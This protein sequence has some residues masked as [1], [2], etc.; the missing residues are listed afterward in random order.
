[1]QSSKERGEH[2]RFVEGNPGGPGRPRRTL[3]LLGIDLTPTLIY[4]LP[5]LTFRRG[6][7][8]AP[9]DRRTQGLRLGL[10]FRRPTFV[11]Y[12]HERGI[13]QT[14]LKPYNSP[15]QLPDPVGRGR[16]RH[17][18]RR[19]PLRYV[20]QDGREA[21]RAPERGQ[22]AETQPGVHGKEGIARECPDFTR[23]EARGFRREN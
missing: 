17:P 6:L 8:A 7:C 14:T 4:C 9:S 11:A 21:V 15:R 13:Q 10:L 22:V 16:R 1:M 5:W 23:S 2:G 12:C 20:G 3:P 19:P 18:H